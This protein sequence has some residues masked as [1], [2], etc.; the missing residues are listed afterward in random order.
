MS[1]DFTLEFNSIG[2]TA[3][4]VRLN[5][6]F[7]GTAT[8]SLWEGERPVSGVDY[9]TVGSDGV[10]AYSATGRSDGHGPM[11]VFTF[12]TA[13]A[14][15]GDLNGAVAVAFGSQDKNKLHLDVYRAVR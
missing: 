2:K 1:V 4:G 12:E 13:N 8:S 15:L 6:P 9:L 10:V 7:S 14:A 11:E 3:R 5:V